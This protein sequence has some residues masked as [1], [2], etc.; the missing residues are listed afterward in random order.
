[1]SRDRLVNQSRYEADVS[2]DSEACL[3]FTS[4][5]LQFSSRTSGYRGS[6]NVFDVDF[7][8]LDGSTITSI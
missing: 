5:P 7:Q 6:V 2:V 4:I 1:M 8:K 3:C